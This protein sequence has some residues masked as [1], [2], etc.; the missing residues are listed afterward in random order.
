MFPMP[1]KIILATFGPPNLET[2]SNPFPA[3]AFAF[4]FNLGRASNIC[5]IGFGSSV[6]ITVERIASNISSSSGIEAI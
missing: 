6:V 4:A 3:K 1:Q 2:F 5:K